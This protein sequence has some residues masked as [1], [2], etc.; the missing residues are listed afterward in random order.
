[1]GAVQPPPQPSEVRRASHRSSTARLLF[2]VRLTE[3][4]VFKSI[5]I[6]VVLALAC[7]PGTANAQVRLKVHVS[8]SGSDPVGRDLMYALRE[9][10]RKAS[11]YSLSTSEEAAFTMSVVT[12]DPESAE[13]G[14]GTW[15]VA[16]VVFTMTNYIPFEKGNPQTWLPI[17]LDHLVVTVGRSRTASQGRSIVASFDEAVEQ[18]REAMVKEMRAEIG[19]DW[20]LHL[21]W[22]V[23]LN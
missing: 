13:R 15:S 20:L 23:G 2:G 4:V 3:P 5:V 16:S 6:I 11:A 7:L 14:A 17:H 1:M 12:L 10:I 21:L 18:F 8:H 22:S 19:A 9:E